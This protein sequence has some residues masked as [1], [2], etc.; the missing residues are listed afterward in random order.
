V[1]ARP[2]IAALLA[3]AVALGLAS[4][5]LA[6]LS[7]QDSK[8]AQQGLANAKL[9]EKTLRGMTI[10]AR[11]AISAQHDQCAVFKPAG[12]AKNDRLA[13]LLGLEFVRRLQHDG[14]AD[15]EAF[16]RKEQQLTFADSRLKAA[17]RALAT[18]L[19][20]ARRLTGVPIDVC[21]DLH[22]FA[23]DGYTQQSLV[24]W[25]ERIDAKAGVGEVAATRT[26]ALVE[27][28]RPALLAAG[29]TKTNATRL[30]HAQTGDIF[31]DV[32]A[33]KPR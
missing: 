18:E 4:V 33:P 19:A 28:S 6:K 23:H 3:C 27:R 24:D 13:Q 20:Y 30:I 16:V 17:Q 29:L 22:K 26:D 21:G 31:V 32:F 5:A 25:A 10:N 12:Q 2:L 15:Y 1:R 9:L 7:P 14:L 11:V 8:A